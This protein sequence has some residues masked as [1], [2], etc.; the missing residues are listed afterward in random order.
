MCKLQADWCSHGW[1]LYSTADHIWV[2]KENRR[3]R[4]KDW[5]GAN[6][7]KLREIVSDQSAFNKRLFLRANHTY[8]WMR[9]QGTRVTVTVLSAT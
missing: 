3:D 7:V 6:D 8:S 5:D 1:E 9:V 2:V 4:K